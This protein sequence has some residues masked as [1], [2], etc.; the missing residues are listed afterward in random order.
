MTRLEDPLVALVGSAGFAKPFCQVSIC[1][2]DNECMGGG[3]QW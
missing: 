1:P 3:P 2:L